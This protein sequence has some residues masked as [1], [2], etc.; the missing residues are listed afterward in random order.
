MSQAFASSARLDLLR[1]DAETYIERCACNPTF[2]MSDLADALGVSRSHLSRVL[3]A[4][5]GGGFRQRV[6]ASRL[7]IARASLVQTRLS[8]KEVAAGAGFRH[9]ADLSRHFKRQFGV[10]PSVYRVI[11][12]RDCSGRVDGGPSLHA[13]GA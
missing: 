13:G 2:A 12:R 9:Q 8:V 7:R 3:N 4:R 1:R 6:I 5:S 10:P 11:S